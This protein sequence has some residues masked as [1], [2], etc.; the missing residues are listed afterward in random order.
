MWEGLE[1][2]EEGALRLASLPLLDGDLPEGLMNLPIPTGPAGIAVGPDVA[3]YY[4]DPSGHRLMKIDPCDGTLT[5]V[6]CLGG[7][8][9]QPTQFREPRGVLFHHIRQ[10]IFVVDSGNH[11][12]QIFDPNSFQ[13]LDIWGQAGTEPGYF[14]TPWSLAGDSEGNVYVMDY[15][16]GRVQKFDFMGNFVPA[17]WENI[18][19]TDILSQPSDIAVGEDEK[20]TRLYIVGVDKSSGEKKVFFF[21]ANGHPIRDD[22]NNPVSFGSEYLKQPMGIV[23][24]VGAVY[25]GDNSRRRVLKFKQDGTFIGESLRY[26]GPVTALA[27]DAN[28]NLLV[29]TGSDLIPVRLSLKGGYVKCGVV[30]GGPFRN[31]S[32]RS[33]QWHRL[34]AIIAP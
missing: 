32:S 19:K 5:P 16:N 24:T 27:L 21:D 33:E 31:M 25:V 20:K 23:V 17:F 18:Q 1:L 9:E 4:S 11:R 8:G 29:H 30:W 6:P 3:I 28:G 7:E 15:G 26:E 22:E 12:I 10:A 2:G 14:N 34:K 13:L